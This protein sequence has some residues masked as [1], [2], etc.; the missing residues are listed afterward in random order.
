MRVLVMAV[1]LFWM[2]MLSALAAPHLSYIYPA[3]GQRGTTVKVSIVGAGLN[4]ATSFFT[5]GSGLST[6]I[7]PGTNPAERTV[8]I[9]VAKDAPLGLQQIR[10]YDDSGLSNPKYFFVGQYPESLEKEPND[11]ATTAPKV[12]L[13]ITIN[14]RIEKQTDADAATFHAKQGETVVCEIMALRVLGQ[15]NDSWLKGYME[16]QDAGGNVLASSE[17]TSDDYYRWDPVI[18]FEPP[19]EGDY[20]VFYRDINWRGGATAVYRLTIG[21]VPH[22]VALFPLGGRRGS[23]VDVQFVGPNLPDAHQKVAIPA[24]AEDKLPLAYTGSAGTTNTR[25]FHVSDLLDVTQ[26]SANHSREAAQTVAYPCVV[27]GRLSE[28]GARDY[29]RFHLD[30]RQKVALEMF[31]R[32]VGTPMDSEIALYDPAGNLLETNDDSRGRDSRLERDLNPGDYTVMVHD[33]DDRGGPAFSYRLAI[34]PPQP[35]FTVLALPDN[36]KVVRGGSVNLKIHVDRLDGFDGDITVTLAGLS[37]GITASPL[38]IQKG[39]Q[40]GEMTLTASGE[41]KAGPVKLEIVGTGKAGEKDLKVVSRTTET[42]N[43]QGT[44][45]QREL[46]GPILLV[47]EK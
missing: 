21:I 8:E 45:Y 10:L 9:A 30:K 38:V 47:T 37:P 35:K 42:Y 1:S 4:N 13:P 14:G 39:K 25:P 12:S 33:I 26:S 16:I 11:I 6:K 40:D 32:R 18:A 20:T 46:I 29:Y 31:S 28:N 41:A 43:I 44:A 23:T 7:E 22:A 17:G 15:I 24:D 5:T 19:K 34:S 27:N 36:M 2:S 3:G